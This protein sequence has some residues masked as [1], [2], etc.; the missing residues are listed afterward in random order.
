MKDGIVV[1]ILSILM[2]QLKKEIDEGR[3]VI[4]KGSELDKILYASS[5]LIKYARS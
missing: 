5:L 3:L 2:A 1:D 4:E